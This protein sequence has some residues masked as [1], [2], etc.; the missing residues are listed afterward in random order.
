MQT[1]RTEVHVR[2]L[3]PPAFMVNGDI[4]RFPSRKTQALCLFLAASGGRRID[5]LALSGL[6]WSSHEAEHA[7][8]SLRKALSVLGADP[9]TAEL[10]GRDRAHAWFAGDPTR[11]DLATFNRCVGAGTER[12]YRE[13]L[14][15]WRGEPLAGLDLGEPTYDEWVGT[16][17]AETV[18]M[19]VKLL[20]QRLAAMKDRGAPAA[21]EIALCELIA[22][23]DPAAPEA[24][25]RLVRL[26]AD[27]GRGAAASRQ[28][29]AYNVALMELDL[30]APKAL[31]DYISARRPEPAGE[32]PEPSPA[33][34]A[35]RSRPTVALVRPHAMRPVPDLFSF[36]HAELIHQL[37]RFR[38]MRCY[39]RD[40]GQGA[41]AGAAGA[42]G[43]GNLIRRVGFT[44]ALDH[45]YRLLIWNE[46]EANAVY[47]RV[48]NVRRQCTVSCARLDYETLADRQRAEIVIAAALNGLEQDIIS[49][50]APDRTSVFA[51]WI[52]AYKLM[53][54][55]S[56]VTDRLALG[57]LEE[58]AEDPDG[59]SLSL[60]HA[61][62]ASILMI[63]RLVAPARAEV[64]AAD[65][66]RA[67]ASAIRAMSIDEL[68]PFNHVVMG[69]MRIQNGDHDR[70][71][72]CFDAALQLNPYSSRTLITAAEAH[73]Y[74]GN[75]PRAQT[76]ASRAI[77]VAGRYAPAYYANYLA[78]IAYLAGDA[79]GCVEHLRR[80]PENAQSAMVMVAAQQE[81]GD[82][83]AVAA[84][85]VRFERELRRS[86][87]QLPVDS[88][89]LARWIVSTN[90][91]RDEDARSRMF[92]ALERAGIPV[93][94]RR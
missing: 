66:D 22:R 70:A 26:Y 33:L 92:G 5:R 51:R 44:D 77:E 10:V 34:R 55:W 43:N 56:S 67:R 50:I 11:S 41:E 3:G 6:L 93:G 79:A 37:T 47:M 48:I 68:E 39:E 23:I 30:A 19:T 86:E 84:A 58:L 80:G 45:D 83:K 69:W 15:L 36:A 62:I 2:L 72:Q 59:R 91:T 42:A 74:C 60:V 1:S 85:K 35:Q 24:N 7:R 27:V 13:A 76:L 49:D 40:D 8:T 87:P 46:P 52:E 14:Q 4:V 21:L 71:L 12:A 38:T 90:M 78:N 75:L 81:L 25:E 94:A 61:S 17:R 16:F 88:D 64:A 63:R 57:M 18:G 31:S 89:A 82:G 65:L 32:A 29:R 53:T 9:M 54:Q 20:N 28:L 73:A